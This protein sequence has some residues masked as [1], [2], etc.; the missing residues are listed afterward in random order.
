MLIL[1]DLGAEF[2]T[3][4]S[5]SILYNL[6]NT[7]ISNGKST[8]ISTNLSLKELNRQ[9]ADRVISRIIGNYSVL[10]FKGNDIRRILLEK[11]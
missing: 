2:V 4:Y 1:D 10:W 8:I 3:S 7:R 11:R 5:T 9:Y 6:V